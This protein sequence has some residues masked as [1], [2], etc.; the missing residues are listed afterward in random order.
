VTKKPT[1]DELRER[2]IKMSDTHRGGE[3]YEAHLLVRAEPLWQAERL[4]RRLV[5]GV[6]QVGGAL[7]LAADP[8][9]AGAV[10]TVLVKKGVTV[11]EL[12][13]AA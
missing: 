8:S 11:S 12:R 2:D 7:E 13:L 5:G 4:C 1:R 9:W 6:R 10:N 3:Q